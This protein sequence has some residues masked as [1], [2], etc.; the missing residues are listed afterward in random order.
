M[1]ELLGFLVGKCVSKDTLE[2]EIVQMR[3]VG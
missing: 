2:S 3:E 1:S